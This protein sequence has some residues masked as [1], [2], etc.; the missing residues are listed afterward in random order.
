MARMLLLGIALVGIGVVA[1]VFVGSRGSS[2]ELPVAPTSDGESRFA[3]VRRDSGTRGVTTTGGGH[4]DALQR[5]LDTLA[6]QVAAGTAERRRLQERIDALAAELAALRSRSPGAAPASSAAPHDRAVPPPSAGD[7]AASPV[8]EAGMPAGTSAVERA[9][10]AAGLEAATAADIKRRQDAL[11]LEEIYLRD[12]AMREHWLDSPRFTEEMAKL[13]AQKISMREQLGDD[14]YDRYLAAMGQ[15]NRVR[16]EDVMHDSP[17]AQ[18]GLLPGDVVVRYGDTRIF[19]VDE[20]VT[21]TH[22]GVLGEPVQLQI[23]RNGQLIGIDVPHGPLGVSIA[24]TAQ[25]APSGR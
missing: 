8:A 10:V 22:S 12:Q 6:A 15:P 2:P 3:V 21:S 19:A 23:M 7:A 11:V 14:A 13:D 16:I 4:A 1:G 25:P 24:A 17:A 9:L 18:A 20:L 5:R